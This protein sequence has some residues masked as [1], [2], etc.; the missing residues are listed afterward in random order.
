MNAHAYVNACFRMEV[1]PANGFLVTEKPLILL[2]GINPNFIHAAQT[3]D[4]LT[5]RRITDAPT[6]VAAAEKLGQE[7]QP[8]NFPQDASP[9]YRRSLSQ[10]L[11]YKTIIGFLGDKV[12][13]EL[14]SGGPNIVRPLSTGKQEFDMDRE[15]WP[16]GEPVP[17]LESAT[18]ISGK[19]F[20]ACMGLYIFREG[21]IVSS[22][23][24]HLQ[25]EY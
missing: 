24:C 21:R 3:E 7:V 16:V 10:A 15:A 4:F 18:Q 5:R 19:L 20:L 9:A 25:H 11:L 12:K 22:L 23:Y 13:P 2:G 6:V 14:A 8:D 17:K 1:D